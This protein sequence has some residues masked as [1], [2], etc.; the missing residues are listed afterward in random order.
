MRVTV[1]DSAV[2]P[3]RSKITIA[4]SAALF[5]SVLAVSAVTAVAATP[6]PWHRIGSVPDNFDQPGLVVDPNGTLHAVWVQ[7]G[8]SN[9]EN[10][11]HTPAS[12]AGVLGSPTTVQSGWAEIEAIPDLVSSSSGLQAFWGGMRS[13]DSTETNTDTN[14]A[15]APAAG[16]PWTLHQGNVAK[17]PGD[18]ASGIGAALGAGDAPLTSWNATAGVYVH[19]GLDPTTTNYEVQAQLGGCCGYYPDT[20]YDPAAH[21][22]WVAWVSNATNHSGVYVQQIDP[23][24]AAPI[25]SAKQLP[26]SAVTYAGTPDQFDPKIERTPIVASKNGVFVAYTAGYPDTNKVVLWKVTASGV[27]TGT[28]LATGSE[29]AAPG[30]S[31]DSAGRLWVTW[32]QHGVVHARRSNPT[33]TRWGATV[34]LTHFPSDACDT[35]Y[36]VT[37]AAAT[38]L[39][40]VVGTWTCN[41]GNALFLAQLYPGLTV[42]A[43]PAHFSGRRTVTFTVTDAGVP[44]PGAKVSAGGRSATTN[45]QGKAS[46]ALGPVSH[47][48]RIT[49]VASKLHFTAGR[50]AVVVVPK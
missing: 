49:A 5:V 46:F 17:G 4:A 44:V 39:V 2:K 24:T 3:R 14:M 21:A 13:L 9:T 45:A 15:S 10:V 27:S 33:A 41:S 26:G 20:A 50:T 31:A 18:Y 35:L 30:I 38:S 47:K 7:P 48:E 29:L 6:S 43:T 40:D 1:D 37:P 19:A 12:L 16:T 36:E 32:A 8:A 28:V 22:A 42:V 34:S 11:I 25:G 23:S